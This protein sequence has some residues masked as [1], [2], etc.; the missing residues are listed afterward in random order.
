M[1]SI[2]FLLLLF[3]FSTSSL[4]AK[5]RLVCIHGIMGSPWS[6]Y[7]YAKNFRKEGFEV[8]NWGYPSR[9]KKIEEHAADL[10]VELQKI[11]KDKP[12]EPIHFLGHSLGCLVIRCAL[13]HPDC[14]QEAKIGRAVLL[15]PPNKG[16]SFARYLNGFP[17]PRM[18][19]SNFSGKQLFTKE[20]FDDLGKFPDTME[21]VLVIAGTLGI[22]PFIEG[23]N[24]GAVSVE[25]TALET[26]HKRITINR[27]HNSIVLSKDVFGYALNFFKK[28]K[29]QAAKKVR[30]NK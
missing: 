16:S 5:E 8:T 18:I 19:A 1:R 21:E 11:A 29:I 17:L 27:G 9:S 15:A 26:P 20:S 6:L 24:D 4:I 28:K 10:V 14:P 25:E 2:F 30:L 7:L 23:S 3:S 22:N 13:N 12:K